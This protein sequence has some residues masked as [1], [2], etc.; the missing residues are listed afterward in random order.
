MRLIQVYYN[1]DGL[2]I[3]IQ[4]IFQREDKKKDLCAERKNTCFIQADILM[5]G[6]RYVSKLE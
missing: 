4:L 1:T 5:L 3:I 2:A 6:L